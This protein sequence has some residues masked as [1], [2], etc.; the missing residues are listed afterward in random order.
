MSEITTLA[1]EWLRDDRVAG[2]ADSGVAQPEKA[3]GRALFVAID[4]RFATV[5]SGIKSKEQV[6]VVVT[7][8]ISISTGL[9]NGDAAGG[10]TLATGDRVLLV[11]QN[12]AAA[13]G[14]YVV[15]A[16]GSATRAT[17]MD[18]GDEFPGA[19]IIVKEGTGAG[20]VWTCTNATPPT[21]GTTAVTFVNTT[22]VVDY[23]GLN[24]SIAAKAPLSQVTAI[25]AKTNLLVNEGADT[26]LHSV[27]NG[28]VF[29]LGVD[30]L[31]RLNGSPAIRAMVDKIYNPGASSTVYF[32]GDSRCALN[33]QPGRTRAQ[34]WWYI[35][36]IITG[37]RLDFS[38][39]NNFG[40]GGDTSE[41]VVV[42]LNSMKG[43]APGVCFVCVSTNDLTEGWAAERSIASMRRIQNVLLSWGHRVIWIAETPRGDAN[44]TLTDYGLDANA[45][46]RQQTIRRWQL[47]QANQ[48]NVF[49]ADPFPAM[50]NAASTAA[51]AQD[52]MLRDSIHWGAYGAG[53]IARII[54]PIVNALFPPRSYLNT[55]NADIYS[56]T[57]PRGALTANQVVSGSGGTASGGNVS[58][59]VANDFTI[60][61]GAG[62][63]VVCSKVNS[64][65]YTWQQLVISGAPTATNPGLTPIDP[66][67]FSVVASVPV[68]FAD[69]IA[70]D[71]L[72][73]EAVFELDAGH[74]GIRSVGMYLGLTVSGSPV[75]NTAG[76]PDTTRSSQQFNLNLGPEVLSGVLR[77]PMT[78]ALAAN[79]S[80]GSLRF[81]VT[82]APYSGSATP[83]SVPLSAT[84]RFRAIAARKVA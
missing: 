20:T 59:T 27:G 81:M 49:V 33:T 66:A 28:E 63:T 46:G 31:G 14:V 55:S 12:T 43:K 10:V 84:I 61:A 60:T 56:A 1:D 32:L 22:Q 68:A 50:V 36:D 47:A 38:V 42:R 37:G 74:T 30:A 7:S 15:P 8:N 78:D 19:T 80:A 53:V 40:V 17:D 26:P 16:S 5:V 51:R 25:E 23:T 29:A 77:V 4:N 34:G 72:D 11:A 83:P 54:A 76:E 39:A 58:G 82:G 65:G 48:P 75:I 24:A 64:G 21:V 13:N 71:R 18:A 73:A 62:L 79:P 67:D 35:L 41:Q 6:R 44:A 45:R 57:N 69:V 52:S 9:E 3:K 2:V 70:G